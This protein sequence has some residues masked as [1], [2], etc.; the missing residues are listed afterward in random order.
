[1][2][3]FFKKIVVKILSI[4]ARMVLRKYKPR[5]VGVT[6]SVGKTSTKDAMYTILASSFFV[7][8]SAKSF[9]SE[10]GVPLTILG[11]DT[12]WNNPFLWIKN[13]IQ[14]FL[15]FLLPNHYPNWLILEIGL[16]R[17]SDIKNIISWLPLDIAV[18]TK[19]AK[20]PVHVEFFPSV[21]AL[22][23][24]KKTLARG[25]TP[26][27][28]LVVNADDE[29]LTDVRHPNGGRKVTFSVEG[30]ATVT[31]SHIET[32]YENGKPIGM[33]AKVTYQGSVVPLRMPG[34]LGIPH[35]YPL[36]AAIAVG[37]TQ[38]INMVRMAD[39][40]SNHEP[41][42]GRMRIL[43]GT[44]GTVLIDDTY[45]SSPIA[46]RSA[47]DAFAG[48]AG[49]QRKIVVLGDMMELG[50]H[51][52][53]KHE[54]AGEYVFGRADVLV[55]VGIRARHIAERAR[56]MGMKAVH[57]CRTADEAGTFVQDMLQ[58][59]DYILV[60]GSQSVRMEKTVLNLLAHPE[61]AETLLVRQGMAWQKR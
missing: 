48:L 12:G 2:K 52:Q 19:L 61:E 51:T 7:R 3:E 32:L 5:I 15:V 23:E 56:K 44:Q 40:L 4:E 46:L 26:N 53:A 24:E 54:E 55:A 18:L 27:G 28:I 37:G 57:E 47:L 30:E 10:F 59:G 1:M 31:A 49:A 11:C 17:P 20:T 45:N 33:A 42:P 39:A 43:E 8:K 36:L 9:N 22:H 16:D 58:E 14:G 6:G 41:P 60:K 21:K 38:D 35:I 13:I 29:L 50:E 34:V 25:L